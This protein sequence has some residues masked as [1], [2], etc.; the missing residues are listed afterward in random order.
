MKRSFPDRVRF[1][2]TKNRHKM[3]LTLHGFLI[4]RGWVENRG[5]TYK[6]D[7]SITEEHAVYPDE[8]EAHLKEAA[9]KEIWE[10]LFDCMKH[11]FY[12]ERVNIEVHTDFNDVTKKIL[13]IRIDLMYRKNYPFGEMKLLMQK[14]SSF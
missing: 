14:I 7:L 13:S 6:D 5:L 10:T 2:L 4:R 12:P 9:R 8:A 1:L 11:S 3:P